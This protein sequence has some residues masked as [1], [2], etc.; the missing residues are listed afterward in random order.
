M[1]RM[2]CLQWKCDEEFFFT[3]SFFRNR[4]TLTSCWPDHWILV[5][6]FFQILIRNQYPICFWFCK[7]NQ[8][9][10][11]L[12]KHHQ[13]ASF[14]WFNINLFRFENKLL[15]DLKWLFI[16]CFLLVLFSFHISF[17]NKQYGASWH[18]QLTEINLCT[19]YRGRITR[20]RR[21]SKNT[22]LSF[23]RKLSKK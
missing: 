12:N 15:Y 16:Q 21:Q 10:N 9:N 3:G 14:C 13:R 17:N 8:S 6:I 2:S 5:F 23:Q 18:R 4:L 20:K 7:Y 19:H 11:K 22:R 1:F